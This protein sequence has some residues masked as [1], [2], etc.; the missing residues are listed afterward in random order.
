MSA[1]NEILDAQIGSTWELVYTG[2]KFVDRMQFIPEKY[3]DSVLLQDLMHEKSRLLGEFLSQVDGLADLVDPYKVG[4]A[5]IDKLA[6]LIGLTLIKD[7][8]TTIDDERALLVEVVNWYKLKGTYDGIRAISRMNNLDAEIFDLYC[9]NDPT[10][11]D[12]F[13]TYVIPAGGWFVGNYPNQNPPD[14]P[15]GYIKT[16]HFIYEI[17]LDRIYGTGYSSYLWKD[18]L[19]RRVT[20]LMEDTRPI[21]TVPH[22]RLFLNPVCRLDGVEEIV[23]G[24]IHTRVLGDWSND[25]LFLDMMTTGSVEKIGGDLVIDLD[26]DQVVAT[27]PLWNL[28]ETP[29]PR[30]LDWGGDN[31]LVT[32]WVLGT[33]NKSRNILSDT[34]SATTLTPLAGHT[35]DYVEG[36]VTWSDASG[37][38]QFLS[39][40]VSFINGS[41]DNGSELQLA[42]RASVIKYQTYVSGSYSSFMFRKSGGFYLAFNLEWVGHWRYRLDQTSGYGP[43][44]DWT[45]GF[46]GWHDVEIHDNGEVVSVWVD[47]V[48]LI[49]SYA[50][51][52][53][54]TYYGIGF[55]RPSYDTTTKFRS[56]TVDFVRHVE[57]GFTLADPLSSPFAGS[58]D[59]IDIQPTYVDY[60]FTVPRAAVQAGISELAFYL[61]DS[62]R[63]G[64]VFPDIDKND[65]YDLKITVRVYS[66]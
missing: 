53:N 10:S 36:A 56:L 15:A 35:P 32:N 5:Y 23:A 3:H 42:A 22:K 13:A 14:I 48:L 16:P 49:D 44:G 6:S 57:P 26:T 52:Q 21:N 61:G 2:T 7:E 37:A 51:T 25:R 65:D 19:A 45:G 12:N 62:I 39:G 47:G 59:A 64:S 20:R 55:L 41:L 9:P 8:N 4:E 29:T 66:H 50:I 46:A 28:D 17:S 27:V 43:I 31:L 18:V 30:Y 33:G 34:F 38:V 54:S 11:Y 63:L 60:T 1:F 58:F 40:V 24:D